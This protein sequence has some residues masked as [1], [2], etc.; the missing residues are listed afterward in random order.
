MKYA[1]LGYLLLGW[2]SSHAQFINNSGIEIQNSALLVTNGDWT[3]DVTTRI[4]N[5]GVISTDQSF[6]NN[7][8]LLKST[9]GFRLRFATDMSFQ[10]GGST[11]GFLSKDGAG[12]A[13]V[14]GTI[15]VKD[16]LLL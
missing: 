2:I 12:A 4:T 16:S 7:G 6:I 13:L 3:N 10:P 1:L 11:L 5:N 14:S 9:G 15:A 8:T